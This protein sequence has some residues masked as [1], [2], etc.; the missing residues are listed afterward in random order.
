MN[1]IKFIDIITIYTMKNTLK[2]LCLLSN[3]FNQMCLFKVFGVVG[4]KS[5]QAVLRLEDQWIDSTQTICQSVLGRDTEH[6][7][8]RNAIGV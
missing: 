4:L 1:A 8:A 5:G 2:C 6:Q 7:I 3:L